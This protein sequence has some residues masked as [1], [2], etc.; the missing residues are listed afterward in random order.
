MIRVVIYVIKLNGQGRK[1]EGFSFD[2]KDSN[3]KKLKM[4]VC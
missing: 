2:L 1:V 4:Y 3:N